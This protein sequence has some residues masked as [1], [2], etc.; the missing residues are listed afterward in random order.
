MVPKSPKSAETANGG[1]A[2]ASG[3]LTPLNQLPDKGR[4]LCQGHIESVTFVPA[5]RTA[6]F[7]AIVSETGTGRPGPGLGRS[8]P[9]RLRIVWLG[10]R[11][12]PGIE[13]GAE[14]RVEGMLARGKDMPTIFN[15][16]YEIM[17]RQ[18]NE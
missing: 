17:S 9:A 2:Q 13:A 14:I 1:P 10:R 6:E 16:R 18:E 4:V 8:K 7:S 3:G 15:P 11:R 12:V 5:E